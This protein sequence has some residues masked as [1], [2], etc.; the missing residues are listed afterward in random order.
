MEQII[1][2]KTDLDTL[3][4]K[5][6]IERLE[7]KMVIS[8]LQRFD[9]NRSLASKALGLSRQGLINKIYRFGLKDL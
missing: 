4:L 6:A 2:E 3:K 5:D 1:R 8:A 9:G 7:R